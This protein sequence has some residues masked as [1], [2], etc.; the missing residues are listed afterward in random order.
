MTKAEQALD[1]RSKPQTLASSSLDSIQYILA[2][3]VIIKQPRTIYLTHRSAVFSLYDEDK[4]SFT[5]LDGC[6]G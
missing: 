1:K 2:L 3:P 5:L 4:N 6:K